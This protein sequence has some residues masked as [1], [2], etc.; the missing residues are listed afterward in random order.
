MRQTTPGGPRSVWAQEMA[1]LGYPAPL[2][3]RG[4]TQVRVIWSVVCMNK[5]SGLCLA[6]EQNKQTEL[7]LQCVCEC[8]QYVWKMLV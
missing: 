1:E 8:G 7:G 2:V 6:L 4:P 5:K 3:I